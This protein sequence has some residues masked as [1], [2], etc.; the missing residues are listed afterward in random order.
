MEQPPAHPPQPGADGPRIQRGKTERGKIPPSQRCAVQNQPEGL[1]VPGKIA[2][3]THGKQQMDVAFPGCRDPTQDLPQAQSP[4]MAESIL[5][6]YFL[7]LPLPTA[8][9][10]QLINSVRFCP[11]SGGPDLGAIASL[12][13]L[14]HL[15]SLL[16]ESAE[17]S[18]PPHPPSALL[19]PR[20]MINGATSP[21][22]C[23]L[24]SRDRGVNAW[25]ELGE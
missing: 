8:V 18:S 6:Q 5:Q 19:M 4:W 22:E 2:P 9:F 24:S 23:L 15:L 16:M 11:R 3:G 14:E 20:S 10:H 21:V 7:P 13:C 1:P 17:K 12:K 25:A